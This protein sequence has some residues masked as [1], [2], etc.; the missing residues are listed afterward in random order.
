MNFN[1]NSTNK[2]LKMSSPIINNI[3]MKQS[4]SMPNINKD[5]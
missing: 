5:L 1:K 3:K 2:N 4:S